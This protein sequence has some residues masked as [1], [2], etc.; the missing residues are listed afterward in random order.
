M[1]AQ[2]TKKYTQEKQIE[3]K[4]L[5]KE[6]QI[7]K[8]KD[9]FVKMMGDIF[10]PEYKTIRAVDNINFSVYRGE[11][12]GYVGPNGSGKSTTIK[13]LSGILT[14]TSGSVKV[15]GRE[16][17][18]RRI[19]NNKEIGVVFGNRSLLWWDVPV[20]ESYRLFQK[21]YEIPEKQFQK[22]LDEC[23]QIMGIDSYLNIPERQLSLGQKTR[24]HITAAF[25]HNPKIV[26]LDEPTIGLDSES[27]QSIRKFIK[28]MNRERKMTVIVTSHDF[29]DIETLCNRM[30]LINRGKIII[31]DDIEQVQR[32]FIKTK[33]IRFEVRKNPW[34]NINSFSFP[35]VNVL[36]MLE[37]EIL[38]EYDINKVSNIE[39]M[40]YV[41]RQCEVK[42]ISII[43]PDIETITRYIIDK[44]NF[45]N[46][47]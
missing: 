31:D 42:D 11:A 5:V 37:N 9:T 30:L 1:E 14:P 38:L 4:N 7:K 12:V 45:S 25:L 34:V 27:K 22:N 17:Y 8:N 26:Y 19:E 21:M 23:K 29:Q 24:C 36:T 10:F 40:E 41:A 13:M 33:R 15:N 28:E 46:K 6:Y 16:P 44:D 2:E 18:K 47:I 20:I 43:E 35:G 3:V 32:T 39:L